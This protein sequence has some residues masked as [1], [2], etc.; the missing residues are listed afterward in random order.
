MLK[1]YE[2]GRQ[3]DSEYRRLFWDEAFEL[4]VFYQSRGSEMSGFQLIRN[5]SPSPRV[6]VW[7][8]TKGLRYYMME[9]AESIING[10]PVLIPAAREDTR[11]IADDF[12]SAAIGIDKEVFDYVF[13]FLC[14]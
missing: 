10:S 5:E 2:S 9:D 4:N 1:E 7:D 6:I 8:K 13:G 14:Q 3:H 11:D 12:H